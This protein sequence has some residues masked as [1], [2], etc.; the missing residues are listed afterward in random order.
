MQ[1]G[2]CQSRR[3]FG[4]ILCAILL[5]GCLSVPFGDPDKS[6]VDAKLLGWWEAK[7]AAASADH[8]LILMQAYDQHTFL[9]W[10]YT[11]AVDGT[12]ITPK[13]SLMFKGWLTRVGDAR[14]LTLKTMTPTIELQTDPEKDRYTLVRVDQTADGI[15]L[16]N[17]ADDFVKD[18]TTPDALMKKVTDN[19][20]NDALYAV[21]KSPLYVKAGEARKDAIAEIVKKFNP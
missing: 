15:T 4:P 3:V 18:C 2:K 5:A 10:W 14:F 20:D 19:V 21:E 17:V 1:I 7:P 9:V 11:Y 13:G 6:V 12:N 16:R 8:E